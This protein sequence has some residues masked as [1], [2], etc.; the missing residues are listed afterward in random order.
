MIMKC[1]LWQMMSD[2]DD[3]DDVPSLAYDEDD[4]ILPSP[5]VAEANC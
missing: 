3:D 4:D 1:L 2:N 5:A